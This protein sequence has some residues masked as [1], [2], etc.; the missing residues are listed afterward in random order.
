MFWKLAIT[1]L[2]WVTHV[3]RQQPFTMSQVTAN[4]HELVAPQQC[5]MRSANVRADNQTGTTTVSLTTP[6]L[7][8]SHQVSYY[9]YFSTRAHRYPPRRSRHYVH[10]SIVEYFWIVVRFGASVVPVTCV[11]VYFGSLKSGVLTVQNKNSR[12]RWMYFCI[13]HHPGEG[14]SL[15]W[16]V[17]TACYLSREQVRSSG[18]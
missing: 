6:S 16:L 18:D 12:H 17:Q 14:N 3:S 15:S 4:Q 8:I 9:S 13:S 11:P 5:I 7:C 1:L 2:T 10:S